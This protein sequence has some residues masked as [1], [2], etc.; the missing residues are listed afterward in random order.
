MEEEDVQY[1]TVH[2]EVYGDNTDAAML[3]D[4]IIALSNRDNFFLM[5][6]LTR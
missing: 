3:N 1:Q 5:H 4:G 6:F 2:D